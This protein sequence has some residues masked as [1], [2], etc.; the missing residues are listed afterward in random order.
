MNDLFTDDWMRIVYLTLLLIFIG[1]GLAAEFAGRRSSALRQM[2]MWALIFGIGIA[3][4]IWWE[5]RQN[6]RQTVFDGRRIEVPMH[7]DGHF[8]LTAELNGAD[9]PFM[10]DTGAS[11]IALARPDAQ[12]IGIDVQNLAYL[13]RANTANG[14]VNT[15][16]IT[17]DDFRIGDIEDRDVR[18]S[19]S[20]SDMDISLLGMSYLR[21][22][23]RVGF[24]GDLLILER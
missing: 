5:G 16:N 3:A 4:A 12:R 19:V 20:D 8:Y 18:A 13:G 6:A 22:F 7:R 10:V 11:D 23:A 17:I 9:V 14:V 15:A 2:G 24:E 21:R 1:G